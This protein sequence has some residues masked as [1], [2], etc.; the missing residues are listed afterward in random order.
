MVVYGGTPGTLGRPVVV[1]DAPALYTAATSASGSYA[2]YHTLGLVANGAV[3]TE[4]EQEEVVSEVVTGLENLVF[5][6]QGEYAFNLECKGF[7]WDVTNGGANP[8]NAAIGTS[9]NW[10]K[11]ATDKKALSGVRI[12]T[13]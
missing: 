1:V 9:S 11:A 7:A 4:S 12:T 10:D 8:T 13:K 6:V 5:R 2:T 3:V